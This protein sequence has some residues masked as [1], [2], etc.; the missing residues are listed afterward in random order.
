MVYQLIIVPNNFDDGA[1]R[2]AKGR[3]AVENDSSETCR[4]PDSRV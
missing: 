3:Q 4:F 1:R 2:E